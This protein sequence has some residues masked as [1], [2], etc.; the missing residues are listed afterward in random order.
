MGADNITIYPKPNR[1][2][3]GNSAIK[4]FAAKYLIH[5]P[6]VLTNEA[7]IMVIAKYFLMG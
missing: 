7:L 6:I 4:W 5:D 2:N 3:A 1:I